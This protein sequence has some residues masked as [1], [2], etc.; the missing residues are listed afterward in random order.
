MAIKVQEINP[1]ISDQFIIIFHHR[2]LNFL[3]LD[4]KNNL[5]L[6][7]HQL[8]YFKLIKIHLILYIKV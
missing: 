5:L 8:S 1:K 7:G 6:F 3:I 4:Y 2:K